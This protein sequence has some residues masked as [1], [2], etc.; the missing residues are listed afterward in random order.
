MQSYIAFFPN[1]KYVPLNAEK[2]VGMPHDLS[3]D[4]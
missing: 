2:L 1:L 4:Q 3:V